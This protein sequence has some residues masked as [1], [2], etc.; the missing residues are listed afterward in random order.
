MMRK[1]ETCM[2]DGIGLSIVVLWRWLDGEVLVE[3]EGV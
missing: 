3:R 2:F 1:G